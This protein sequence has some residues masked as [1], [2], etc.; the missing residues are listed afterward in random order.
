MRIR[1][2]Q[3]PLEALYPVLKTE[4]GVRMLGARDRCDGGHHPPGQ[5]ENEPDS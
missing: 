1:L 4:G 5:Q 2:D 3:V